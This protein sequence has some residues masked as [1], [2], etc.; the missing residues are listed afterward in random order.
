[1]PKIQKT[2]PSPYGGISE[3]SPELMLDTQCID[4]VNCVPDVVLGLQRRNGTKVQSTL[5]LGISNN[6]FH[7]YDRGE[8]NERYFMALTGIPSNPLRIFDINGTE[9]TVTYSNLTTIASYLGS[10]KSNLKAITVQDRTFILNKTKIVQQNVTDATNFFYDR[11]A[12]Y[13]L[14]RSSNDVNNKYNYAVYLDGVT[15][16]YASESSV[17]AATQIASLINSGG[18]GFSATAIGSII[19]ITKTGYVS[20]G[21]GGG[22]RIPYDSTHKYIAMRATTTATIEYVDVTLGDTAL[23]PIEETIQYKIIVQ[24]YYVENVIGGT[25]T[26][27]TYAELEP[28][29]SSIGFKYYEK[30]GSNYI[31][32]QLR[33]LDIIKGDNGYFSFSYWDSW[34]SQASFGWQGTVNKLSDLPDE[35]PFNGV[36]VNI[37][38]DDNND[39]TDY[40]VNY[41]GDTWIECINPLD[42]RGT[43]YNMPIK[44]DRESN[45]TF[46]VDILSWEEPHIG[47]VLTNPNPSFVNNTMNDIIF[48]KNRLGFASGGNII[49]SET[50]GYYN[51]Y[52]KTVLQVNDDDPI[53]V[54]IPS[55]DATSIYYA[56]P[57]QSNLFV[58]TKDT[59][60][61]LKST[62]GLSPNTVEF[63]L[64]SKAP[65][66]ISVE[67]VNA[68]NS[69]FFISNVGEG[70]SQLR[71]YKYS[72]DSL[73]ADGVNLSVQTP[74]LL[75]DITKLIVDIGLGY[76]FMYSESTPTTLY[77]YRYLNQGDSRVQ[78][79]FFKFIFPF[80]IINIFSNRSRV[81][82][83]KQGDTEDFILYLDLLVNNLTKSDKVDNSIVTH[84]FS[85]YCTL[86]RWNIKVVSS[87]E[88][89]IDTLVV[90]RIKFI[91]T[92]KYNVDIYRKDYNTTTTR[93]YDSNSTVDSA[94]SILGKNKNVIITFRS[95]NDDN[96]RLD[97]MILEGMYTQTS[98]EVN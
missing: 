86:P 4:M 61:L 14:S 16:Q 38:G 81:L 48:Y 95:Y 25:T 60:Y 94:A 56:V 10:T 70:A 26:Y 84:S 20:T 77:C 87:M 64:I 67:P 37:T 12:Y 74:N 62:N 27:K 6:I 66:D 15:Y 46:S 44:V 65:M 41:N 42:N 49:L 69:L 93:T 58:F 36:Y 7:F 29:G 83:T 45:G 43:I 50:G 78:S 91:G 28:L 51:F 17:T 35:M 82:F 2:F 98:R 97:S 3:Q 59:Q 76:V 92:G 33:Y 30:Q 5:P 22:L 90:K 21:A 19:K 88:T 18:L 79:S 34:G 53:D 9:K 63:D 71:E 13:W 72:N 55:G 96:F 47:S 54:A 11:P 52:S 57:F 8:G 75:P 68:A 1:M 40:F 73:V 32:P 89:P 24:G 80:S 39:F 85:S 31:N 23:T